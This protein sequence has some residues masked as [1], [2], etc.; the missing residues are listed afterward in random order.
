MYYVGASKDSQSLYYYLSQYGF[1]L[2]IIMSVLVWG[3]TIIKLY[4]NVTNAGRL[5]PNKKVFI[6]H[7]FLMALFL[8]LQIASIVIGEVGGKASGNRMYLLFGIF[9]I[10]ETLTF[11]VE[12]VSFFVVVYMMLPFLDYQRRKRLEFRRFLFTGLMDADHLESAIYAQ[13]SD[14]SHSERS[15]V[16]EEMQ[17][18]AAFMHETEGTQAI[19]ANMVE[20]E[21]IDYNDR[22]F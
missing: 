1:N 22:A 7:G 9:N 6:L 5:L 8:L 17:R 4:R 21:E 10:V 16:R 3:W 11:I 12:Y 19:M 18:L 13:H 2:I 20:V 15:L 14:L